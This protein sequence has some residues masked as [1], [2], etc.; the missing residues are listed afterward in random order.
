MP[1][2]KTITLGRFVTV[3]DPCYTDEVIFK[4][5]LDV[6]SGEY[7]VKLVSKDKKDWGVRMA[8]LSV[9]HKNY[10][11]KKLWKYSQEIG[12]DSG[13]AG[14]FCDTSYR[15]DEVSKGYVG[16]RFFREYL[17]TNSDI[18]E[19]ERFYAMMSDFTIENDWG[20]YESGV[21]CRSGYGDGIYPVYV[22]K[23][24]NNNIVGIKIKFL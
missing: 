13:Q 5:K 7:K 21:A 6:V 18:S 2:A 24:E 16:G 3:S 17:E 15:N 11:G 23:D 1:Q 4:G 19:G 9:I 22:I 8:S 10:K 14:I 12:V 20:T